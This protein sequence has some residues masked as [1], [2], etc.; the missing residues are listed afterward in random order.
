MEDKHNSVNWPDE[1]AKK[2]FFDRPMKNPSENWKVVPTNKTE[3]ELYGRF[4]GYFRHHKHY[5]AKNPNRPPQISADEEKKLSMKDRY[6]LNWT[7]RK[8]FKGKDNH[9]RAC[10]CHP[11]M[12][13]FGYSGLKVSQAAGG[14]DPDEMLWKP[15]WTCC[16]KDWEE[17]GCT[18]TFHKGPFIE[19]YNK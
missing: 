17:E 8:T 9:K 1:D 3:F 14:L 13:D 6:C 18:R 2:Y 4:S 15:H 16:R 7:C 5:V 11:G 12:W 19:D 10:K